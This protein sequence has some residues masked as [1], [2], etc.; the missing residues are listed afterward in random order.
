[1][2][3]ILPGKRPEKGGTARFHDNTGDT[4][5]AYTDL[6]INPN[7]LTQWNLA[8]DKPFRPEAPESSA[9]H[10]KSNHRHQNR[11][12]SMPRGRYK[13]GE[14][15]SPAPQISLRA[16]SLDLPGP[17]EIPRCNP[18]PQPETQQKNKNMRHM[19]REEVSKML[20]G[21]EDTRRH[22]RSM[23]E[24]GDWLGV[25]G[26][27]PYSGEYAVLTPTDTVSTDTTPASAK[28]RLK[29]IHQKKMNAEL[30][31][32]QAK[33]DEEAE[34]VQVSVE[35]ERSKLAKMERAK[36]HLRRQQRELA[37]WTQHKR[38]WSSA[39]EPDLSP[40]TQ[41]VNSLNVANSE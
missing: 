40:I 38:T 5:A 2:N 10:T 7:E 36:E 35:K 28:E 31:Y 4:E 29:D 22:R 18:V 3:K 6:G 9:P 11:S 16:P 15:L 23:K 12:L 25:Q 37:T 14:V 24:S 32:D 1:M 34:R 21:K 39:A 41:S 30:A 13:R 26:A 27:D 19:T 33:L 20:K 8:Q 17:S